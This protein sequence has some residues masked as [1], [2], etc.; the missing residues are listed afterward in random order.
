LGHLD[1]FGVVFSIYA[2][3]NNAAS[4]V[5][6]TASI[7]RHSAC[8]ENFDQSG[9]LS[10]NFPEVIHRSKKSKV[11]ITAIVTTNRMTAFASGDKRFDNRLKLFPRWVSTVLIT[12]TPK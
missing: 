12:V 5:Q 7:K 11:N 1:G 10:I 9:N 6:E 3:P 8:S 2:Y 4:A